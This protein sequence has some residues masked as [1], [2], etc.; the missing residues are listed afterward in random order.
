MDLKQQVKKSMDQDIINW[1]NIMT[2]FDIGVLL[3]LLFVFIWL[4]TRR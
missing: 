4:Y 2:P 3:L 1:R